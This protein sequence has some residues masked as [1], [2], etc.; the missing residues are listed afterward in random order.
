MYPP[1]SLDIY[2]KLLSQI[3][4]LLIFKT[5]RPIGLYLF[6]RNFILSKVLNISFMNYPIGLYLILRI[7]QKLLLSSYHPIGLYP[8][9]LDFI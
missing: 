5:Y 4:K 6:F 1:S 7:Y 9:P 3:V 8:V 2:L